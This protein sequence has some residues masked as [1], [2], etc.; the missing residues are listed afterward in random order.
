MISSRIAGSSI[1]AG[2]LYS[3][4]SA[5]FL[6]V[7]RRIFPDRTYRWESDEFGL[8]RYDDPSRT[9]RVGDKLELIVS[10]CNPVVN[11]WD[12][13]YAARNDEVEVVWPIAVRGRSA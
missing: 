12:Y 11:L 1:V 3:S 7:P 6:T 10:H 13:M 4:P 2:I 8:I 5:I 9:Y